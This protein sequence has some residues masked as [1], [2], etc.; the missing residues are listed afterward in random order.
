MGILRKIAVIF[1]AFVVFYMVFVLSIIIY[2][3]APNFYHKE[4]R[5]FII[6]RGMTLREIVNKLHK[7]KIVANPEAFLILSQVIKGIDP[8]VLYGEYF[9]ERHTSYYRILHKML[10]GNIFFR[11]VTIAEGLSLNSASKIIDASPGLIGQVPDDVMEGWLL[12]E[13]YFY[14]YN[15]SKANIVKRMQTS[16]NRALDSLWEGRSMSLPLKSKEEAVILASIIEKETRVNAERTKISS[17]FINR[18][19]KGMKLQSDPTVIY[20]FTAGNKKLERPIRRS[21]LQNNSTFNTYHINGLPPTP[22][23]NPGI[24]SL[25]AALHPEKTD[26]IYFVATGRGDHIFSS[27]L[28]DHNTNVTRYRTI[29]QQQKEA[30]TSGAIQ[31]TPSSAASGI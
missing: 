17:V 23:C 28:A 24:A 8:K 29:I 25:K 9:F 30:A 16:M 21:D 15:D 10:H 13:T 19:K 31:N 27:N 5:R 18:L 4:D 7:E 12:P 6:E 22:I 14:S 1:S 3:N 2:F 11:K 26:F 20:S